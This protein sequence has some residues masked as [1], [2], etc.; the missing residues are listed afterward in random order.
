MDLRSR[1]RGLWPEGCHFSFIIELHRAPFDV[2]LDEAV[3]TFRVRPW[4]D[5]EVPSQVLPQF[6]IQETLKVALLIEE[7]EY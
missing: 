5:L 6:G 3:L 4:C 2:S 1:P 7:S